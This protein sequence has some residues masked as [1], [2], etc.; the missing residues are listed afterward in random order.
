MA[1]FGD[2]FRSGVLCY[3]DDLLIHSENVVDVIN[4]L[5]VV[6]ERLCACG[7]R[8]NLA[9]CSFF[10]KLLRY[11]GHVIEDGMLK[12]DTQRV[13]V[14]QRIQPPKTVSETR[15]YLGYFGHYHA[16]IKNFSKLTKPISCMLHKDAELKWGALHDT[17]YAKFIRRLSKAALWIPVGVSEFRVVT[18]A[19]NY[20]VGA[21]LEGFTGGVWCPIEFAS[22]T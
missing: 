2:L 3:L 20:A 11:L 16:Y 21:V 1:T 15:S 22:K 18:D 5:R 6:F 4:R 9:K 10:P 14:L 12:P 7:M 8:I 19:S 17:I 13:S